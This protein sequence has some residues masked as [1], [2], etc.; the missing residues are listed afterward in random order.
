[1]H[2]LF[3]NILCLC[4]SIIFSIYCAIWLYGSRT[5]YCKII[6]Q[7]YHSTIANFFFQWCT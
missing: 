5:T 2:L 3:Q 4:I 1:M 7:F 6:A